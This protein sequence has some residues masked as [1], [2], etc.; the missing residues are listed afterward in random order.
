MHNRAKP[1]ENFWMP[2]VSLEEAT[3]L[4]QFKFVTLID[5]EKY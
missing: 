2:F 3:F 5:Y 1:P 4:G